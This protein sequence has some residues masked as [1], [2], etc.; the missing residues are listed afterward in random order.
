MNGSGGST[1]WQYAGVA[2]DS[3]GNVDAWPN[4]KIPVG[5]YHLKYISPARDAGLTSDLPMDSFDLDEDGIINETLPVDLYGNPRVVLGRV[6]M[7][8]A[9]YFPE[10]TNSITQKICPGSQT[11]F[12]GQ[13]VDSAGF[14]S[15]LV[16][17]T[18]AGDS[19]EYLHLIIDS[20]NLEV[21]LGI[22][23]G[24]FTSLQDSA[25]YQWMNC[26][27]DSIVPGATSR[28]FIPT[29]NGFYAVIITNSTGCTDTSECY[30]V[31]NVGL[32]E[33]SNQND[34]SLYPNPAGKVLNIEVN[35]VLQASLVWVKIFDNIGREVYN[36]RVQLPESGRLQLNMDKLS[37]GV[38]NLKIGNTSHRFVKY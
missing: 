24:E 4:F 2:I 31:W 1:N 22:F 6:D 25:T 28:T 19:V 12:D 26:F 9:E 21:D 20:V 16:S 34:F 37:P 23:G 3:G 27:S 38:Y 18:S 17:S 32:D 15:R 13:V 14:Y 8:A 35:R 29:K 7:G 33:N 30:S 11:T 5:D 36:Q 10:K